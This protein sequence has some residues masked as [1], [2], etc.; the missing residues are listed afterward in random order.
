MQNF[1]KQACIQFKKCI[2]DSKIDM[3][4]RALNKTH[5]FVYFSLIDFHT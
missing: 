3:S 2:P 4:H 5:V 1:V